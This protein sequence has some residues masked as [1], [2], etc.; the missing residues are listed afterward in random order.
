M[1]DLIPSSALS[2]PSRQLIF[3]MAKLSTSIAWIGMQMASLL[4]PTV[5]SSCLLRKV[6]STCNS[7]VK[8]FI[9]R[10]CLWKLSKVNRVSF[11]LGKGAGLSLKPLIRGLNLWVAHAQRD[12]PSKPTPNHNLNPNSVPH[13]NE[14]IAQFKILTNSAT[15]KEEEATHNSGHWKKK[16]RYR[17]RPPTPQ[18]N[19][20]PSMGRRGSPFALPELAQDFGSN[21]PRFEFGCG[22]CVESLDKALHSHCPKEKPSH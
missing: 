1:P 7:F 14:L 10:A 9:D 8:S 11:K 5:T 6:M 12:N 19:P 3:Y 13:P 21:G 2:F 22:R 4:A 18:L 20:I 15:K 17:G 16:D